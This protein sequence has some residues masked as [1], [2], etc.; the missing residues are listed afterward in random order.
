MDS[1]CQAC[2]DGPEGGAIHAKNGEIQNSLEPRLQYQQQTK[3]L[4]KAVLTEKNTGLLR[5]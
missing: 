2:I 5:Q 1:F 4:L 3:S